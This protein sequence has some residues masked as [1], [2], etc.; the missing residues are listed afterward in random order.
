MPPSR[1]YAFRKLSSQSQFGCK[2][3]KNMS[4][5][6]SFSSKGYAGR[7]FDWR[8]LHEAAESANLEMLKEL[9]D[10]GA[11]V[12]REDARGCTPLHL[13]IRSSNSDDASCVADG[14][15]ISI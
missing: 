5:H 15:E 3:A 2:Q 10:E 4:S 6:G 11:D 9:L 7:Y 14:A 12:N 1:F 8:T 13:A